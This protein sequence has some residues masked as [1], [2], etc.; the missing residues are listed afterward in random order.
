MTLGWPYSAIAWV[1]A[2]T[3]AERAKNAPVSLLRASNDNARREVWR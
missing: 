3:I 1:S 2:T